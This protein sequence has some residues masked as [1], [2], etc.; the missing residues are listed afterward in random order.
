M[1]VLWKEVFGT[2]LGAS[3][4]SYVSEL[5]EVRNRLAHNDAFT[6]D[7]AGRAADRAAHCPW[8]A[9]MFSSRLGGR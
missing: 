5:L 7:N 3:E 2:V 8:D 9:A 6:H 4:R 1:T